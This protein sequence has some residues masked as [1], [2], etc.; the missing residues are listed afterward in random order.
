MR[1]FFTESLRKTADRRETFRESFHE[2]TEANSVKF[3][4]GSW[5]ND[6]N[7]KVKASNDS[8]T[9]ALAPLSGLDSTGWNSHFVLGASAKRWR[10]GRSEVRLGSPSGR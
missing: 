10:F 1:F 9:N 8:S 5:G 3:Y 2:S 6:F 4:F 7:L